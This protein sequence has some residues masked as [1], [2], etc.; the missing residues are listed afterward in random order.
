M[1]ETLEASAFETLLDEDFVLRHPAVAEARVRLVE[2]RRLAEQAGP[3]GRIPF[4]LLFVGLD[5]AEPFQ[6]L[7]ELEHASI[8]TLTLFLVPVGRDQRG[9]LLEAV[10][11]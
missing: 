10:F 8:G 11:T 4:S 2:L 6:A 7:Y 5:P 9:L 3:S 1:L